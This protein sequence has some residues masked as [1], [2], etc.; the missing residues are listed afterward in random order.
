[1]SIVALIPTALGLLQSV[2]PVIGAGTQIGKA[3]ALLTQIVPLAIKTAQ[4]VMP[5]IKNIIAALKSKDGITTEQWNE[6]DKLEQQI[7]AEFDAAAAAAEAEDA[8]AQKPGS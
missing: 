7:D 2:L 6:L 8:A 1:M 3:I 4:D 5:T